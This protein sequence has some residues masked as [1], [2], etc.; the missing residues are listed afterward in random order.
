MTGRAI[1][2][3]AS[4]NFWKAPLASMIIHNCAVTEQ[5]IMTNTGTILD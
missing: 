4:S 2:G 5:N 3:P 1:I